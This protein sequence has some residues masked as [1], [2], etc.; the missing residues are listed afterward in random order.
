M[1][2]GCRSILIFRATTSAPPESEEKP[3]PSYSGGAKGDARN[4]S[5]KRQPTNIPG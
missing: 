4:I 3:T 1:L 5:I 2:L